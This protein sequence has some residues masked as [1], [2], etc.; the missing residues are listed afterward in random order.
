MATTGACARAMASLR[1]SA[2]DS[3]VAVEVR[4][5]V[6]GGAYVPADARDF[7][8]AD[9][10]AELEA[11]VTAA[12]GLPRAERLAYG[13]AMRRRG[14]AQFA[15]GAHADAIRT[16]AKAMAGLDLTADRAATLRSVALPLWTNLAASYLHLKRP[17]EA[18]RCCDEALGIDARSAKAR[19]RKGAALLALDAYDAALAVF[20]VDDG[21]PAERRDAAAFA[22]K[23]RAAQ[24]RATTAEAA[25]GRCLSA[26]FTNGLG[27]VR[28]E[29]GGEKELALRA[30]ASSSPVALVMWVA[31][32]AVVVGAYVR[33]GEAL[34]RYLV[35]G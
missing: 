13:A 16:Y 32:C 12:Q 15:A 17:R 5:R 3:G 35:V 23:A 29:R 34:V 30:A 26:A 19:L 9:F 24:R 22:R 10:D 18:L 7:A 33:W 14:N 4:K 2:A 31:F 11:C 21:T 25:W 8:T 20:E 27:D 28:S 1:A 6:P